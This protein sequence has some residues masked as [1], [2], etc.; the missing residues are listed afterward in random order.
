MVFIC[1]NDYNSPMPSEDLTP[2]PSKERAA[3]LQARIA[4]LEK[5]IA[6]VYA[7]LPAHSTPPAMMAALDELDEQLAQARQQLADLDK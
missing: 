3:E 1:N 6:D 4:E 5:R 2:E 7:R